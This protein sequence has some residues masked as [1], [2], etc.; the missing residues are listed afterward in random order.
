ML[1]T[2]T[3]KLVLLGDSGVGK[4]SIFFRYINNE[5]FGSQFPTIGVQNMEKTM[6][7][8]GKE[9]NFSI[10]D[11]AGQERFWSIAPMYYR[12]AKAAI[13]VYDITSQKSFE[14]SKRW[15]DEL[16]EKGNCKVTGFIGNK[17]DLEE[18]RSVKS[19]NAQNFADENGMIF[20]EVSA[21][22]GENIEKIFYQ[23]AKQL[24]EKPKNQ[25]EIQKRKKNTIEKVSLKKKKDKKKCC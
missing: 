12:D 7:I 20:M 17:L 21:R 15:V 3:F 10:F 25:N 9:I 19:Q 24:L 1:N 16:K 6:K 2:E 13:I 4:T 8:S 11:T 14:I 22:S 23:I 5:F 18:M